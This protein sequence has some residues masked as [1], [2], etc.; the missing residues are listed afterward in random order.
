MT[1]HSQNNRTSSFRAETRNRVPSLSIAQFTGSVDDLVSELKPQ[2]PL[3][4]LRPQVLAQTARDFAALF[5][6]DVMYAVK[7]NP[8]KAVLQTLYK[9]GIKSF[10]VASIEEVRLT[11]KAAPKARLYFMHPVKSP[12]AIREAYEVHGVRA[13]VL[14]T[15]EELFKILRETDLAHDLEL[16]VRMAL[17]K[18]SSAAIDFRTK[19]GAMPDDVVLLLQQCRPVAARLGVCFHVG[20]QTMNPSVYARAINIAAGVI[21]KSGVKVD[22][23][24]VGGGFPVSYP[25]QAAPPSTA[26]YIKAIVGAIKKCG[27][28]GM[29]LLSEPG[30]ALVAGSTSLVVRVEQRRS[31]LLY[32]ND[33]TYGGLFDAG[34]WLNL[35]YPVRMIRGN[36][37]LHHDETLP[38]RLAGPT[39]DALDMMAGPFDLPADIRT[40]DWIEIGNAGA[41]SRGLR[42][43]FNGFGKSAAIALYEPS[44]AELPK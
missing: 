17:P 13:F 5:P 8:E 11:A 14:D 44:G 16:F 32:I 38:F 42:G 23:L 7:C 39:C 2:H 35:R 40:G 24:D 29:P 28:S 34:R 15:Q 18:N 20:T 37:E 41:Y 10:D 1:I 33:G 6:G 4:V 30:R 25:G 31:D 27:L 36:G 3:Y 21:A 43:N 26:Q 9:N 22:V 12:E 19:F